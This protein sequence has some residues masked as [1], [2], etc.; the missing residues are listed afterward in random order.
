M[1]HSE[2]T[3]VKIICPVGELIPQASAVSRPVTFQG[4]TRAELLSLCSWSPDVSWE[5][6]SC[7]GRVLRFQR[8][9]LYGEADE[10]RT[11]IQEKLV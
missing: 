5:V 11:P 1:H 3:G 4:V 2:I 6:E 7:Q 9:I 8:V 10:G